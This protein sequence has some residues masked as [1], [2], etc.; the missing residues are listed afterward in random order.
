MN[1]IATAGALAIIGI[2]S[3]YGVISS[4]PISGRPTRRSATA[5]A[6]GL[7]S[8][9]HKELERYLDC[10]LLCRGFALLAW[11]AAT[12]AAW[13]LSAASPADLARRSGTE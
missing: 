9:V 6:A 7:P 11:Q 10:D 2:G 12:S 4:S 13:S 3:D 1:A 5:P 8:F